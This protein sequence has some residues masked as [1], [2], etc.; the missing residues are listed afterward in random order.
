MHEK[1]VIDI[2]RSARG[3]VDAPMH[4][5]VLRR[6]LL[7]RQQRFVPLQRFVSIISM[8]RLYVSMGSVMAM[9]AIAVVVAISPL[10]S[11]V[12]SAQEQVNRAFTRAVQISPAMRA[13]LETKM[14]ADM[15]ETLKEAKAAPD[16]KIMTKEEYEKD[17]QFK[18]STGPGPMGGTI[19]AVELKHIEGGVPAEGGEDVMFTASATAIP[20]GELHGG[21]FSVGTLVASDVHLASGTVAVAGMSATT[22]PGSFSAP[23]KYLSYT[24]PKGNKTVL[25]L[26]E[27][28]T[29]VF[30]MASFNASALKQ[31]DGQMVGV[32]GK[33]V[34]M[35]NIEAGAL[36]QAE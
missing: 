9:V 4:R 3:E 21:T 6:A 35:I 24:D 14:K 18:F 27:N 22:G 7:M 30:K 34:E 17:S 10:T 13:E 1:D 32:E 12:V 25:G 28:D 19:D 31:I 5:S 11:T 29:P 23:V 33:E 2:L 26:D 16:L 15:L 36:I 20:A 8:N